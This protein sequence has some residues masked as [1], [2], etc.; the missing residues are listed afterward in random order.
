MEPKLTDWSA[1]H[2]DLLVEIAKGIS[3]V[4]DF[5]AFRGVCISWRSAATKDK[6]VPRWPRAPLLMLADKP[7]RNLNCVE[8][9]F[10]SLSKGKICMRFT[11]PEAKGKRCMEVGFG[12]LL[13][14]KDTSGEINLLN[15]FS[16][17]QIHLPGLQTIPEYKIYT[18]VDP[19]YYF[20]TLA[21]LSH[22]PSKTS[23]FTLLATQCGGKF[24]GLWR[25]GDA[26]WTRIQTYDDTLFEHVNYYKGKFFAISYR[27]EF[28]VLDD[29]SPTARILFSMDRRLLS[30]YRQLYL[31]ESSFGKLLLILRVE[32]A[33]PNAPLNDII[34]KYYCTTAFK[35]YRVDTTIPD[36]EEISSLE[37]DAIFVGFN[38]AISISRVEAETNGIKN[39]CIYFTDDHW[40][41]FSALGGGGKDTGI[42]NVED[43]SVEHIHN[44]LSLICPSMWIPLGN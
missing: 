20:I 27:G 15:P 42:Y 9:E 29:D 33:I 44:D 34:G 8:R 2:L 31:V 26:A 36:Y 30:S 5:M 40:A 19:F 24:L 25:P 35:V 7:E 37:G 32:N 21:T 23:N 11:L 41:A 1:L 18:W 6:F 17:Q 4:E 39:N 28:W 38:D 12:W 3:I 22:N 10:Y 16:H 13:T 14:V 43:R